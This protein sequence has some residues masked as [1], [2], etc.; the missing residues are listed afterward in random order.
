MRPSSP[1]HIDGAEPLRH[2][3]CM[4]DHNVRQL[5]MLLVCA[6]S[7]ASCTAT[8]ARGPLPQQPPL[9]QSDGPSPPTIETI[10]PSGQ[11]NQ[12]TTDLETKLSRLLNRL[13]PSLR[14]EDTASAANAAQ[15]TIGALVTDA[16]GRYGV[17]VVRLDVPRGNIVEAKCPPPLEKVCRMHRATD[18]R[19]V[20]LTDQ[21][22]QS[23]STIPRT[24]SA[25]VLLPSGYRQ[26]MVHA[27]DRTSAAQGVFWRG[28]APLEGAPLDDEAV[29]ALATDSSLAV[30]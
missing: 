9:Q 28:A 22:D 24:V 26:H 10:A 11:P 27:S 29:L 17:V 8:E 3:R 13:K 15:Y 4:V 12:R 5:L 25:E 30:E 21:S 20:L 6:C 23:A 2:N 14:V 19:N 18:G 1:G 7:V 16:P